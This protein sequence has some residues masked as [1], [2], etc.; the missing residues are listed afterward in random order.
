MCIFNSEVES[1][2]NTKIFVT[3]LETGEQFTCY[4]NNVS[5]KNNEPTAMILPFPS[6]GKSKI[7]MFDMGGYEKLFEHLEQCFPRSYSKRMGDISKSLTDASKIVT[8]LPI[9][10]CGPLDYSVADNF[11]EISR[12]QYD[13]FKL[14]PE[15]SEILQRNYSTGYGFLVCMCKKSGEY[16]IIG[17]ISETLPNG[18]MFIPTMHEYGNGSSP[19]NMEGVENA[20][21]SWDHTIYVLN[22]SSVYFGYDLYTQGPAFTFVAFKTNLGHK[23]MFDTRMA[24]I[25]PKLNHVPIGFPISSTDGQ[26]FH[27]VRLSTK[28]DHGNGDIRLVSSSKLAEVRQTMCTREYYGQTYLVQPRYSCITC[29]GR[30]HEL[31]LCYHCALPHRNHDLQQFTGNDTYMGFYCDAKELNG[32]L[33]QNQ[34]CVESY[35]NER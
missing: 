5:L 14:S 34:V 17:V 18:D 8:P 21:A 16:P 1:V 7:T 26:D 11:E 2:A 32:T 25:F 19:E 22:N 29:F 30:Q 13:Y 31:Q 35:P 24:E 28:G 15:I 4:K 20:F 33:S 12:L 27:F 9:L 6:T 10:Q 23:V 3:V